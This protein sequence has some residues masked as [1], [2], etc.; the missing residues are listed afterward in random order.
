MTVKRF[1]RHTTHF[2]SPIARV[3]TLAILVIGICA[4][5][6]DEPRAVKPLDSYDPQFM[7]Y[8][9]Y[10]Q[11]IPLTPILIEYNSKGNV[12][13]RTGGILYFSDPSQ[14]V[15]PEIYDSI[16]YEQNVITIERKDHFLLTLND[17]FQ[18]KI[19]TSDNRIEMIVKPSFDIRTPVFQ[20]TIFF[21]YNSAGTLDKTIERS[22]RIDRDPALY[23][24]EDVRQFFFES[25][26]LVRIDGERTSRTGQITTTTEHFEGYDDAKNPAYRLGIFEEVFYR[27]LSKNNFT[28]YTYARMAS[29]GSVID[30]EER[31]WV[32]N[33]DDQGLPTFR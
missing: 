3:S 22:W 6:D 8:P 28:R 13:R 18:R 21:F 33:Y 12:S 32:L 9:N 23:R 20:D 5:Q 24:Y 27:S 4:C 29:D 11:R 14:G 1:H 25:Q 16:S 17:P 15:F 30:S 31:E 2:R 19:V 7:F 10:L 26:N